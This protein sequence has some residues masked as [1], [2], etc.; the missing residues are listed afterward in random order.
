MWL[1]VSLVMIATGIPGLAVAQENPA[2]TESESFAQKLLAAAQTERSVLF[3]SRKDLITIELA[4]FLI[5]RGKQLASDS[6]YPEANDAFQLARTVSERIGDQ[7]GIVDALVQMASVSQLLARNEEALTQLNQALS[8]AKEINDR[9]RAGRILMSFGR[10]YKEQ[11]KG[12]ESLKAFQMAAIEFTTANDKEELKK[13]FNQAGTTYLALGDVNLAADTF[14]KSLSIDR[15]ADNYLF[16]GN[17]FYSQREYSRAIEYYEKALAAFE[18]KRDMRGYEDVLTSLAQAHFELA[19]YD[20]A[21]VYR[22]RSLGILQSSG[23]KNAVAAGYMAAGEIYFLQGNLELAAESYQ[24]SLELAPVLGNKLSIGARLSNLGVVRELQSN[25]AQAMEY[26]KAALAELETTDA[27][28]ATARVLTHIGDVYYKERNYPSALMSYEGSRL[29]SEKAGDKLAEAYALLNVG[30]VQ[31]TT[32]QYAKA[33]AVYQSALALLEK[34]G[35]DEDIANALVKIASVHNLLGEQASALTFAQHAVAV[36]EP[37]GNPDALW[38]AWSEIGKSLRASKRAGEARV[39]FDKAIQVIEAAPNEGTTQ[40]GSSRGRVYPFL[41]MV[42]LLLEANKFVDALNYAERAKAQVLRSVLQT[43]TTRLTKG[44]TTAEQTSE[45]GFIR[46][47]QDART[48]L[49]REVRSDRPDGV[50]KKSLAEEA[51]KARTEYAAFEQALNRSHPDLAVWRGA[52]TE[53]TQSAIN[54]LRLDPSTALLEY[55]VTDNNTYLF[56]LTSS[57]TRVGETSTNIK[58][59]TLPVPEPKLA[60]VVSQ[61][62]K[63][64]AD[65]GDLGQSAVELYDLLLRPAQQQLNAKRSLVIVPDG[66]L[67][68]LPFQALKPA[69]DRYIIEEVRLSYA[70]SISALSEI[71]KQDVRQPSGTVVGTTKLVAFANPLPDDR[72]GSVPVLEAEVQE[73]RQAFGVERTLV[74]NGPEASE[75][76]VKTEPTK[77]RMMY[78]AAESVLDNASPMFSYIPLAPGSGKE[79]G[80]LQARE[81]AQLNLQPDL[82]VL[83]ASSITPGASGAGSGI[84]GMSWSWFATG[85]KAIVLSQWKVQSTGESKLM[86]EFYRNLAA[87]RRRTTSLSKAESMRAAIISLLR[88]KTYQHPYFWSGF[89]LWGDAR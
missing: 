28:T 24:R 5:S 18:Q 11:G 39:A 34:T 25:N 85:A 19:N 70:P 3:D 36:A 22:L 51:Q 32:G 58:V 89:M 38:P 80:F 26:Y 83:S 81:V 13:A 17:A 6:N 30:A 44:M 74:Y 86:V 47:L 9:S 54:A 76:Q 87:A 23:D 21:L 46:R 77:H 1:L 75:T 84:M 15:S 7:P 42:E 62:R 52:S 31:T 8:I 48:K 35:L 43:T 16:A 71:S 53:K 2:H 29:L 41:N 73:V 20:E 63:L 4:R 67:R 88:E 72:V 10:F 61:F 50:R 78:F 59:Y 57:R 66:A 40:P 56:V 12:P 79:D 69:N 45:L 14:G 64:I 37:S 33:L 65:R 49:T 55:V 27:Q 68:E 82:V 60:E